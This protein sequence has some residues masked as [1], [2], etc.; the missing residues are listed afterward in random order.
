MPRQSSLDK[1][2]VL[3]AIDDNNGNISKA[4]AELGVA[5]STLHDRYVA[6]QNNTAFEPEEEDVE[7]GDKIV[8]KTDTE[9]ISYTEKSEDVIDFVCLMRKKIPAA[10][11][12]ENAGYDPKKWEVSRV[13]INQWQVAGKRRQGQ[14]EGTKRWLPE[15]LWKENLFQIKFKVERR[16]SKFTQD[17]VEL[18]MS[19]WSKKDKAPKI[20]RRKTLKQPHLLEISLFDA[21][22]GK[23]AWADES[24]DDYDLKIANSIYLNAVDDLLNRSKIFD[25]ERTIFPIGQDF[26]NVDNWKGET[27]NGTLVESTDDRFTKIFST[28]VEAI[29]WAMLRCR[30]TS[31]VHMIWSP[32]NHDRSSSWYLIKTLQQYCIGAGITDVTFDLGPNQRKYELYGNTLLGFTH[33]CDEKMAD[34][35]LIMARESKEMWAEAEFHQWHV[36]HFH[37]KKEAKFISGD[38]FNGVSV[39]ILPS[40]T[41]TDSYHYRNGWVCPKRSAEAYLWSKDRGL[42][43]FM[44]HNI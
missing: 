6:I 31:P 16:M 11:I 38:T 44:A 3:K 35:P 8:K 1:E 18:L 19:D 41:A 29:K 12:A 43:N 23:L 42:S 36:G 34:L 25:I 37:K 14:E 15:K 20:K 13:E 33:S 21:H 17:A 4:A 24:G 5:R 7:L 9:C 40:L 10:K 39:Q 28:G 26:F 30:E 27:S 32:G 2:L 22:F